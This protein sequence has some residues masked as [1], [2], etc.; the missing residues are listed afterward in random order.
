MQSAR[1]KAVVVTHNRLGLLAEVISA[2]RSQTVPIERIVVVDNASTDGTAEFLCGLPDSFVET[3]SLTEN[4]GGAH[5]FSTGIEAAARDF[6]GLIWTL[7]DDA[8]PDPN[9]LAA[10]V[11]TPEVASPATV[12][13][14]SQVVD[15]EG[16][17]QIIHRGHFDTLRLRQIPCR[18]AEYASPRPV[19]IGYSSFVGL[20]VKA[21]VVHRIGPPAGDMFIWFDDIEYTL[22]MRPLGE[23]FLVPTSRVVHRDESRPDRRLPIEHYWKM[24]YDIRNTVRIG[25]SYGSHWSMLHYF[26]FTIC[27]RLC[28]VMLRDDHR[29]M[30]I[31]LL[32]KGYVDGLR[33][34]TGKVID[35]AA[36]R[37]NLG[38]HRR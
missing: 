11:E 34:L 16:R 25:R 35:P 21:D 17:A 5:G 29:L 14:A 20:L 1:V 2:L 6:D 19:P 36:F 33:G 15:R 24:Y 26:F 9:A 7:D 4:L 18:S 32:L 27:R 28:G 3:I 31:T 30:R 23:L 37:R 22:R 10:L 12:G 38:L 13:L 8:I